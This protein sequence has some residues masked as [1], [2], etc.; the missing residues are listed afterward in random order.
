[1]ISLTPEM[2]EKINNSLADR[3]PC[4]LGTASA[5]GYPGLGH[6]GSMMVFDDEHLA[7]WE[8][9][10]QRGY[11]NLCETTHVVVAYTDLPNRVGWRFYGDAECHASGPV[12]DEVWQRAPEREKEQDPDKKGIAVLI[13]VDAVMS[14]GGETIQARDA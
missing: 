11:D 8:R 5:K 7:Y 6:R 3:L 1:M 2:H 13:R 12:Y 14:L 9:A 4:L 10:F